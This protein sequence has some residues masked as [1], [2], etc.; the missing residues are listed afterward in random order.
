MTPF[1]DRP[2]RQ[3]LLL[4]TLASS[5]A[6][7]LLVSAAFLLWEVEQFRLGIERDIEAQAQIV[8]DGSVAALEFMDERVA[9]ET[10]DVLRLRTNIT[11]ACLY[12]TATVPGVPI[13]RPWRAP[14]AGP[15]STPYSR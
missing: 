1:R 2:I 13:R 6:A 9:A 8:A 11:I 3:K 7:L 12:T 10:L 15:S 5:V 4:T 14:S